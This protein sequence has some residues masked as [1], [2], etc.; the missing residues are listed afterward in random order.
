MVRLNE[1]IK[2]SNNIY[3]CSLTIDQI[4]LSQMLYKAEFTNNNSEHAST[5]MTPFFANYG[6]HPLEPSCPIIPTGN[7]SAQRH[8]DELAM[9]RETVKQ[10]RR[11][12]KKTMQSTT[13]ATS[14]LT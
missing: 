9:I 1:L 5:K 12:L 10:I 8:L 11:K 4:E 3:E 13:S 2:L 14:S 7:P 6:Y